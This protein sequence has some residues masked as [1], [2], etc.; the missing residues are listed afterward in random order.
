MDINNIESS[1]YGY[2]SFMD[3]NKIGE[4]YYRS[5]KTNNW[6]KMTQSFLINYMKNVYS[7]QSSLQ[8]GSY[9]QKP[10]YEFDISE[11]GKQRHIRAQVIYDRVVQRDVCD[12]VIYPVIKN[13]LIYDNGAS[14]KNKGIHFSRHRCKLHLI[15]YV[16]H[17]GI[18]GYVLQIDFKKFFDSI[19]H[20]KLIKEF[21]EIIDDDHVMKLLEDM[22]TAFKTDEHPDTSVGIGSHISQLCGLYYP[23]RIDNY[24]KI[25]RGL[26][27]YGR[28]ADDIYIIHNDINVLID[29]LENIIKISEELGLTINKNK[30]HITRLSKGFT[31]LKIRY[32]IKETGKI[33]MIIDSKNITRER[34]KIR[35]YRSMYSDNYMS[36]EDIERSVKSWYYSYIKY[37]SRR[38]VYNVLRL[39][40]LL[41]YNEI[42]YF[43]KDEKLRK[44]ARRM[45]QQEK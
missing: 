20:N 16:K 28:Y 15:D 36:Y 26:K 2:N 4:S 19:P 6:K 29:V 5:Q 10:F 31:F 45:I 41:F 40:I 32:I 33:K 14:I 8:D 9:K 44:V 27:Y 43:S 30:T 13:K 24:C 34:R 11:R 3:A 12:N 35:K 22:I 1:S 39:F 21:R 17:Y 25:V 18:N 37:D 7:I 38:S 42:L 23:H